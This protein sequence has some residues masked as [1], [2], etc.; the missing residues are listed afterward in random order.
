MKTQLSTALIFAA[1]CASL[2]TG[3]AAADDTI[4]LSNGQAVDFLGKSSKFK[5]YA[6][7]ENK[8]SKFIMV[9]PG[10]IIEM[11]A[12]GKKV[13]SHA[14]NSLASET[15][16]FTV[17]E[18]T[19]V[20][21]SNPSVNGTLV[22]MHYPSVS[23]G[24]GNADLTLNFY[25][26]NRTTQVKYGN[27]TLEV[28]QDA[29]KFTFSAMNWPFA[30][31]D[32]TLEVEFDIK[33]SSGAARSD[34]NMRGG[35]SGKQYRV[36]P[37]VL[38]MPST[39]LVDDVEKDATVSLT[40]SGNKQSITVSMPSFTKS[41]VYDPVVTNDGSD[42]SDAAPAVAFSGAAVAAIAALSA[43]VYAM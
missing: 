9:S 39:V 37:G 35:G 34:G 18:N 6:N 23:L 12:D 24:S 7:S 5:L 11:G 41:L 27:Q 14:I 8:N 20:P 4:A 22:T 2:L 31:S 28:P 32:N 40:V 38:D 1:I 15:G 43:A 29:V 42:D 21:G 16:T 25:L 26:T 3:A 17:M 36:G 19:M 13:N 10:S 33:S 30:N